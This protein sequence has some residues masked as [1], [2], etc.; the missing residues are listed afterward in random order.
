[1]I[2]YNALVGGRDIDLVRG[3]DNLALTIMTPCDC[4]NNCK[5][6][7]SKQEYSLRK[8]NKDEVINTVSKFWTAF[9]SVKEVV[10]TG[11][12]P[13]QDLDFI[14]RMIEEAPLFTRF[15]INTT[16]INNNREQFIE[17]VND[18]SSI[19]GVNISRHTSSYEKDCAFMQD[20]AEDEQIR[21]FKKPVRIN[22]VIG[23]K[24]DIINRVIE[25]WKDF[26]NVEISFRADFTK[27]SKEELHNPYSE[28]NVY[29]ASKFK[30]A[31]NTRCNVCD[32]T[33]FTTKDGFIV[34]Y[35]KGLKTTAIRSGGTIEV[36]D[37]VLRQDGKI[38]I[39]WK[40][41]ENNELSFIPRIGYFP[42][43]GYGCG[44]NDNY[45]SSR[46]GCGSSGCGGTPYYYGGCGSR[47][48][49][50]SGC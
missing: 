8:P 36:N 28:V 46:G 19:A 33:S 31:G 47:G 14:S 26:E 9:P 43:F 6:C 30:Y 22:C 13:M 11:G 32:T 39:D 4:D 45:S 50:G 41:T 34:K 1:M 12:E 29:L 15:F 21:K 48:C 23:N 38:Y 49:G 20:I 25:R 42:Y 37:F 44:C 2:R 7:T 27:T 40:F 5:F 3:R 18:N 24:T 16:F 10:I 35:H 17:L